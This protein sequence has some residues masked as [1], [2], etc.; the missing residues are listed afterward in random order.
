[1][2]SADLRSSLGI[3]LAQLVDTL[4][5]RRQR[6]V[7][8]EAAQLAPRRRPLGLELLERRHDRGAAGLADRVAPGDELILAAPLVFAA[9]AHQD[10]DDEHGVCAAGPHRWTRP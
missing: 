8:R 6:D 9:A 5:Q 1:M 2:S 10:G 3:E 4:L 7:A